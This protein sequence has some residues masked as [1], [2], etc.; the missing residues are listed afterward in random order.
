MLTLPNRSS[1]EKEREEKG[2]LARLKN[3]V[4]SR[5]RGRRGKSR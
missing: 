3:D 5:S 1:G 2:G 4:V